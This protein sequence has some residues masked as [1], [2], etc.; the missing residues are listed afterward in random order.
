MLEQTENNIPKLDLTEKLESVLRC[1][2]R[3]WALALVLMLLFSGVMGVRGYVSYHP[4]YRASVSFTVRVGS[5]L[6]S[7]VRTYNAKAAEQ[8]AATFP[9]VLT[10][11]ALQQKVTEYLGVSYVPPVQ[12]SVLENSNIF[13]MS[14]QD[15]DPQR[16]WDVLNA[17]IA[18]YPDVADF[19]VGPTELVVMD[20]SGVPTMPVNSFNL[21]SVLLRGAMMGLALW[22]AFVFLIA[23]T[24]TTVHT[25]EQLKRLMNLPCLGLVPSTKIVDKNQNC[26]LIHKDRGNFGF[27]ESIR[28]LQMRAEKELSARHMQVLMVTSAIPGEGKTTVAA[29][30]AIAFARKGKRVLLIDCDTFNPSVGKA[31]HLQ[32][33][34]TIADLP[35]GNSRERT[36]LYGTSF[37]N[38]YVLA[39]K[40]NE[41]NTGFRMSLKVLNQMLDRFRSAFDY[42]ILDTPP[43]SLLADTA[44]FAEAA[45]CGI[46]VIRQDHASS[47]QILE[48]T[49]LLT[50]GGLPVIGSVL[51]GVKGRLSPGGYHY[52]YGYGYG[53]G[54]DRNITT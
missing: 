52:G 8:M 22:L 9:Y 3:F 30:L 32:A 35:L 47:N 24:R 20:E 39:P 23:L 45:D 49:R 37:R 4:V 25:E 34:K 1:A 15:T 41:K 42:V 33:D 54:D 16:A 5:T 6:Y 44:D 13:T 51:N 43:C 21:K 53:Y 36:P 29:N 38:L 50:D 14:V 12:A 26:P 18:C 2:R 27:S 48:G 17:V 40:A 28:M 19:V 46:M 7:D 11:S 10:S 31:I